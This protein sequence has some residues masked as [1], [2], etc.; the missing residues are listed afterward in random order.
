MLAKQERKVRKKL[1]QLLRDNVAQIGNAVF[2]GGWPFLALQA[3]TTG[4]L[5][6][7]ANTAFQDFPRL[8]AILAKDRFM[9]R[10]FINRGEAIGD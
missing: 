7:A 5:I 3:F 4:I 1:M 6:L 8:S 9:P 2:G 10:Q